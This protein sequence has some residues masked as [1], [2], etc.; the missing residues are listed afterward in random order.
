MM[1]SPK[2]RS[3]VPPPSAG[4]RRFLQRFCAAT[5]FAVALL[6]G[7][8]PAR[9]GSLEL[10]DEA[11]VLSGGDT[12]AL[13]SVVGAAPFDVRVLFTSDYADSVDLGRVVG[14][15]VREPN[16]IAVGVDP[17]H[18]H[19][20][21]HFGRGA[22]IARSAW[23][24]IETAGNDDFRQ[25]R[26]A[27]GA[28]DIVRAAA[29]SASPGAVVPE[30]GA[31]R[32]MP[33]AGSLLLVL[34][35]VG[36][37]VVVLGW[38]LRRVFSRPAPGPMG[39]GPPDYRGYGPGYGPGYPGGYGPGVGPGGMGPLGAGAIGAG[40]GGLAGYEL[41]KMEGER[42]GRQEGG[43]FVDDRSDVA[44]DDNYDAG[45]GGSDWDGGGGGNDDGGG[46]GGSDF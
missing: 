25:S 21:V 17:V 7:A 35:L 23:S 30:G 18:H 2:A 3:I 39:Y 29:R 45:G 42:E 12:A 27:G 31:E 16:E 11:H 19:V 44:P 40:L 20:Q 14:G 46:G 1:A 36:G 9:A 15:L 8:T 41:G 5:A 38:L 37:G 28:E 4:V 6:V 43:P 26:W 10:R 34:L 13:R 24:S 32:S 22:G 33:G